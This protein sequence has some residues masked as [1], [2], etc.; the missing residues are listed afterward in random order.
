MP[1]KKVNTIVQ[2]NDKCTDDLLENNLK[3]KF[4]TNTEESNHLIEY[5]VL[6]QQK[7]KKIF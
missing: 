6:D 1:V 4:V 2:T 3:Y 7:N 5:T